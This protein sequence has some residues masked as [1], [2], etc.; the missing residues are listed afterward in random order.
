[1]EEEKKINGVHILGNADSYQLFSKDG[2][3]KRNVR[4][5]LDRGVR[6]VYHGYAMNTTEMVV[7]DDQM[8]AVT[9]YEGETP[10][11]VSEWESD[12]DSWIPTFSRVDECCRPLSQ[13]FG[14]GDYYDESGVLISDEVIEKSIIHAKAVAAARAETKRKEEEAWDNAVAKAKSEYVHILTPLDGIKNYGERD[15]VKKKNLM[16]LLKHNFP[17]IRFTG[18]KGYD[19]MDVKWTDG[20]SESEVRK[21]LNLFEDEF[22]G[23]WQTDYYHTTCTPFT[24]VFGGWDSVRA[25]REYSDAFVER[26]KA[27]AAK[28]ETDA[29]FGWHVQEVFK[30]HLDDWTRKNHDSWWRVIAEHTSDY[31]KPDKP[32]TK[33]SESVSGELSIIDYSEKAI[34][35]T[36]DTKSI[37]DVL[38]QLGGRFNAKLS[39]G[40]GWI[41]SKKKESDVRMALGI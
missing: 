41:F 26:C 9:I 1:M 23:D 16:A 4:V 35:V 19:S 7:Y 28:F 30:S 15:K 29:D 39:C 27:E 25:E 33:P 11:V 8:N 14:I 24:S 38:K 32:Q 3:M 18:R 20:P 6:I 40:A 37:K 10:E 2:G 34:A 36:G 17:G 31:K 12:T 5:H 21:I 13:V 22:D